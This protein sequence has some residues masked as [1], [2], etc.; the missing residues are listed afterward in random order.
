MLSKFGL[1]SMRVYGNVQSAF[2]ITKFKGFDPEQTTD[3]T[4][5]FPQV[6]VG[7]GSRTL[8]TGPLPQNDKSKLSA[9]PTLANGCLPKLKCRQGLLTLPKAGSGRYR[10]RIFK[11][12]KVCVPII[13]GTNC[14]NVN[15]YLSLVRGR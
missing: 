13:P 11:S 6:R 2:T 10:K 1:G 5:A 4:R 8:P 9:L 12:I 3:Q 15:T 7:N 14:K